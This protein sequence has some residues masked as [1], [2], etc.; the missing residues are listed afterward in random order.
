METEIEGKWLNIDLSSMRDKLRD[1]GATMLQP[2]RKMSRKNY[3]FPGDL[4]EKEKSG[5]V[6]VRDEGDKITLSYKQLNDRTVHGTK[7]V[8][9]SIDSFDRACLF[10]ESIGLVQVSYQETK[11]ESWELDGNEIELDTWPWIPSFVE[12]E[13]KSEAELKRVVNLLGLK[14]EDAL[15]GSVEVAYQ[16]VYDVT[17]EEID[18]WDTILFGDIPRELEEKRIKR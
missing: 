12:I 4:L 13:A 2:E 10:L 11:R 15:H 5:W 17:E 7:E 6:R 3:D 1:C 18:H 16:D 8:T 9:L 14:W